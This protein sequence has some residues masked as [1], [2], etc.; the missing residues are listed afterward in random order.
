MP[1]L[2]V[3]KHFDVQK[4]RWRRF[5]AFRRAF[6]L[7]VHASVTGKILQAYRGNYCD[8]AYT[9]PGLMISGTTV[10]HGLFTDNQH[11]FWGL[12]RYTGVVR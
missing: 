1:T 9:P 4:Y 12:R 10:I 5:P 7:S 11:R 8:G 3:I 6:S 2:I